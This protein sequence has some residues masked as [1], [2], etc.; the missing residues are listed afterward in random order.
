VS[1]RWERTDGALVIDVTVPWNTP[2]TIEVPADDGD[3]V[4]VGGR[5]VDPPEGEGDDLPDGVRRVARNGGGV[6]VRVGSGA[7]TVRD[8]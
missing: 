4:R 2:A 5:P 6:A 3:V 1:V 7:Y 8:E